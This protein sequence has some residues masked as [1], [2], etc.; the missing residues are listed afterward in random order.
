MKRFLTSPK[1]S[2]GVQVL[3]PLFAFAMLVS[4]LVHAETVIARRRIGNNVEAMTYDPLNDRA[5][6]IDGNDVIGVAL[7]PFDA[8]VLATMR[9]DTGGIVGSGYR[10]LFDVLALPLPARQPK[11]IL[12]VPSLHRYFFTSD[13]PGGTGTFYSTDEHGT[14]QPPLVL[15]G[16]SAPVD[17]WEGLAWIPPGAPAHGG[18]IAALG[19]RNASDTGSHLYY[20]RLDGTVEQELIPQPGTPLETYFC[21][22][23]VWPAHPSTLLLD[24]CTTGIFAMDLRSGAPV[25]VQPLAPIPDTS[26][27]E[28]VIVRRNGE[29]VASGYEGRLF[30]FDGALHRT[31][32]HDKLFV[33]GIGASVLSLA[34]N[35][36]AAEF[37]ALSPVRD[38][39]LAV[40]SD[41]TS[42]RRLFDVAVT[43]EVPVAQTLTYLGG[44]QLGISSGFPRGIDIA[45][46]VS[47]DGDFPNGRS[48]SRIVTQ[49]AAF[50]PGGLF[51]TQGFSL[52]NPA[53]P[54]TYIL[55]AFGD[56]GALKVITTTGG[57]PDTTFYRD[58]LVPVRLPDIVLS[59]PA[60]GFSAQV[61][62]NGSGPQVF[63]GAEIYKVDGTLV[64]RIDWQGLN[65][66]KPPQTGVWIGGNTFATVDGLTSTVV[67]YSVP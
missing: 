20:V 23:A 9:N 27:S 39:V 8:V 50:P 49:G 22:V 64:H 38:H 54:T 15:N 16:L 25:G 55:R 18:T 67:V 51:R 26:D 21:A 66:S 35:F 33:I 58:G 11:G 42:S 13:E 14:P 46:V 29:I 31:P 19:F 28:G 43:N 36:D 45:Q 5:V 62:D 52:L 56:P 57:T 48:I 34:W 17:T 37:V 65:L 32:G 12:Y 40:S 63:T 44:N 6:V 47:D 53:D 41:L 10:K 30:A 4:D 2:G 61:F 1:A 7:N 3:V 24:D 60:T 59:S